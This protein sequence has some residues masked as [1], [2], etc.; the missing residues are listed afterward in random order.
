M[1]SSSVWALVPQMTRTV[2]S[3]QSCDCYPS[4]GFKTPS[5]LPE[6]VTDWWC[7]P[8]TEY[9]FLGFSYGISACQSRDQLI[10]E[11]SDIRHHF[12]SRYVR[13]YGACDRDGFYD[14]I[15]EAAWV[16]SLGVHALIWFGFNGD[17]T[18]MWRRD[19]LFGV[20]HSN[21]KAKFVTRVVQFGSEPLYDDVISARHLTEQV[22]AAKA[23]LSSLG[24]PVTVSEL[25]Y[26][27][28]ERGGAHD[29]LKAQ[30]S[31][32]V[33]VLPFFSS[34]ASTADDSWDIV[35]SSL[36]WMVDHGNGKKIYFDENGWP[37]ATHQ[38]IQPNTPNAVADVSNEHD[39][40]TL[41][42]RHCGELKEVAGGG[43]GWFAHIYS[44]DQGPG[45]GIYDSS[46]KMKFGFNARTEC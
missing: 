20:L 38:G 13:L 6:D 23:N 37:S 22:Y 8:K 41:L 28:Q 7:D 42:D 33:H 39:Y 34:D 16:N 35:L 17:D 11:F 31:I 15:V 36:N 5:T 9:A 25:V 21:P 30:D 32:S 26:G 3:G 12:N 29:V 19:T 44:D 18:W 43:V 46:G 1:K 14:D 4:L 27:Y 40:F 2:N 10:R 24:I 45:Y